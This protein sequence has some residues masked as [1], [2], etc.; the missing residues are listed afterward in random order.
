VNDSRTESKAAIDNFLAIVEDGHLDKEERLIRLRRSLDQL[1]FAQH[2]VAYTFDEKEYPDAPPQDAKNLRR[3]IERGFPD[4]G[5][6]NVPNCITEHIGETKTNVGDAIDDIADIT[7]E[8]YDVRWYWANTS[9]DNA[10]CHFQNS[11]WSHW[12][13]HL[14]TLQLYLHRLDKGSDEG[15][16]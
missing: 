5:Y 16:E 6:Y 12:E 1:A 8:L 7:E 4:L 9:V 13:E 14:R 3:A 15:E 11:Y 10:L 2:A